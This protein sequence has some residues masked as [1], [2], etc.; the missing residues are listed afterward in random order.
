MG[1]IEK[2]I[3]ASEQVQMPEQ[4]TYVLAGGKLFYL[5]QAGFAALVLFFTCLLP[6]LQGETTNQSSMVVYIDIACGLYGLAALIFAFTCK[7]TVDDEKMVI[8]GG[9]PFTKETL[10]WDNVK[11]AQIVG[12]ITYRSYLSLILK[13][14]LSFFFLNIELHVT[15]RDM[16]G[17]EGINFPIFDRVANRSEALYLIRKKLG[18]RIELYE[19]E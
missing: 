19:K 2:L 10:I 7:V 11:K 16:P 4:E 18:D 5:M 8:P 1:K 3:K 17:S 9:A 12:T 6:M 15:Y 13:K 14:L